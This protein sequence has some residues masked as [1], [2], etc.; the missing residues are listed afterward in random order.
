MER[1][2]KKAEKLQK[3]AEKKAKA[4]S[5]PATEPKEKKAKN[6]DKEKT[7]DAY[8]PKVI[9]AGRLEWWEERDLFKP[10]FGPD[11]KVK[12]AGNFVIPIPPPNVTGSLHMGHALTNALQDTMIRWQR[13]KGKTTLWL[14]GM[15]HA[16]ISTQSVVEKMLWKNE[17]KTRH[18]IGRPAMTKLIWDWKDQYH[19]NIKNALRRVGGSFD[20][21]RE[22]FTMD[23]NLSAAVTETFVRL[24]EEGIIYRANRLVNWCVVED[25]V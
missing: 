5:K 2:R 12:P 4:A 1:E 23:P 10:E 15:D 9:E 13:M 21:S 8:D 16:G 22:A 7:T 18:D 24:H 14:P 3:L 25:E 19:A 20:W 17:K 6:V 11:G